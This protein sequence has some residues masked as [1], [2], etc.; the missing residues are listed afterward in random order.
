MLAWPLVD[1]GA[2][3]LVDTDE[4]ADITRD[5]DHF[6]MPEVETGPA[7]HPAQHGVQFGFYLVE[8]AP[9]EFVGLTYELSAAL[10]PRFLLGSREASSFP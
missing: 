3:L 4:Y 1:V 10:G 7:A 6:P 8:L 5:P 9:A 2:S